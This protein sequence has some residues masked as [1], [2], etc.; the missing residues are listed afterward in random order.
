LS[1]EFKGYIICS[2]Q[3]STETESK[4][5]STLVNFTLNI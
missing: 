2:R 5:T 1:S 4:Y 3:F